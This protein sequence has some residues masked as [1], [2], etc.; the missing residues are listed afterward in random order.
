[1]RRR[2][3]LLFLLPLL[4]CTAT[5]QEIADGGDPLAALGASAASARYATPFWAEQAH[6]K[7]SLWAEARHFC[8]GR[9]ERTYPNCHPVRLVTYWEAP[10]PFPALPSLD[11]GA[12]P[13][14]E[15]VP[16]EPVPLALTPVAREGARR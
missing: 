11:L 1:M 5:P 13:A 16:S 14:P 9:D 7:S 4:A 2:F 3:E 10:P 12:G 8:A 6:H 15:A